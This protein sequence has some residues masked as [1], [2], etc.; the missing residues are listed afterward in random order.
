M[1]AERFTQIARNRLENAALEYKQ[2]AQEL[3]VRAV[4]DKGR[5]K[6]GT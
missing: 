2:R 1:R 5:S 4:Q 6:T 3:K